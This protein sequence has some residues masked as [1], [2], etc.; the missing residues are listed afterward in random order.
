[1]TAMRSVRPTFGC[2]HSVEHVRDER[3]NVVTDLFDGRRD[4][5]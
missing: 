1:M 4:L 5:S 2:V 3:A